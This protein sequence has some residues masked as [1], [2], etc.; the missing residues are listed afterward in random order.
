MTLLL[1]RYPLLLLR[2]ALVPILVAV[3]IVE[4]ALERLDQL[5][6]LVLDVFL[7]R[8]AREVDVFSFAGLLHG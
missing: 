1:L 5:R 6:L 7:V 2:R 3:F 8:V 4:E